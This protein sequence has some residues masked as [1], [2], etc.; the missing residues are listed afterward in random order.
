MHI[1]EIRNAIHANDTETMRDAFCTLADYP[2]GD[3][4]VGTDE[5]GRAGAF[6]ALC[7][8]LNADA[9]VM[10]EDICDALDLAVGA[11]FAAGAA[12]V[13]SDLRA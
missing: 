13:V 10:P 11:T 9:G 5:P 3:R 12:K 1:A 6:K 7:Q 2:N 4:I 8:K